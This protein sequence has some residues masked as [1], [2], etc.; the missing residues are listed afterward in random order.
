[1]RGNVRL[2]VRLFAI[3]CSGTRVCLRACSRLLLCQC[4]RE[5]TSVSAVVLAFMCV[6]LQ[7]LRV[8][9]R[10]CVRAC[11]HAGMCPRAVCLD[12]M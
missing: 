8:C 4:L 12:S 9:V 2:V 7:S 3:H 6:A 11:Q 5:S 1:M 10:A